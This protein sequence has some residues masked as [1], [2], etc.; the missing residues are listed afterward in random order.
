MEILEKQT[1]TIKDRNG[2]TN[3]EFGTFIPMNDFG[4]HTQKDAL[5]YSLL[6]LDAIEVTNRLNLFLKEFDKKPIDTGIFYRLLASIL[7]SG[8]DFTED[9]QKQYFEVVKQLYKLSEPFYY[10]NDSIYFTPRYELDMLVLGIPYSDEVSNKYA[11]LH[12]RFTYE[13]ATFE[14]LQKGA[15]ELTDNQ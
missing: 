8:K 10:V 6:A 13:N 7:E 9:D 5:K 12:Y 4:M 2:K 15:K 14:E 1:L 11:T 3:E